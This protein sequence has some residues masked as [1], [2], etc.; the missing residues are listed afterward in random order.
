MSRAYDV[1]EGSWC[2]IALVQL[3]AAVGDK[4]SG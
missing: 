1:G 3:A 2:N 4:S